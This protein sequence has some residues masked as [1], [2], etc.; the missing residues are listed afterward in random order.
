MEQ[1]EKAMLAGQKTL[2]NSKQIMKR[3]HG[4]ISSTA[5]KHAETKRVRR[6][7]K[8]AIL[9]GTGIFAES[10]QQEGWLLFSSKEQAQ[11]ELRWYSRPGA[12]V[13]PVT[14]SFII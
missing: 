2:S 7:R 5:R 6:I 8:F 12:K 14:L 10:R 1:P 9:L 4:R 13:I 11:A 3:S